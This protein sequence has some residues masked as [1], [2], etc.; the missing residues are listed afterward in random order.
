MKCTA[1]AVAKIGC[2]HMEIRYSCLFIDE[3]GDGIITIKM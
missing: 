2:Y 3:E 1:Y